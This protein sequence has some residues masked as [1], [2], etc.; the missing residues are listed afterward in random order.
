[1]THFPFAEFTGSPYELGHQHG[2]TFR[3]Q[4]RRQVAEMYDVAAQHELTRDAA[5]A[6]AGEQLPKIEALGPHWIDELRGLAQ[7]AGIKFEEAVSLQVRPGSGHMPDGCT[8]FGVSSDATA[9][10]HPL[11]GQNRDLGPVYQDRLTVSLLRPTEGPAVLMHSVPGELGG[12]GLNSY[13][14]SLFANSLWA[15]SGRTWMAPP[16]LRRAAL[17]C[18][19]ADA[20]VER[21][22]SMD[23]PA[24]GNFLLIDAAGRMR[25]LEILPE[26]VAVIASDS[27]AYA[28][29]NNC[30]AEELLPHEL[31]RLPLPGSEG[32]RNHLQ[33]AFDRE[34]GHISVEVCKR[35]LSDETGTPEPVCHRPHQGDP[36]ATVA[37]MIAEP[38]VGAL[39]ISF[40]PPSDGRFATHRVEPDAKD[41]STSLTGASN[42]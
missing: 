40:G 5:L 17:E 7:G 34:S 16:L 37:G 27:G 11:G 32:R 18:A 14:L 20:A 23:G 26:G 41:V 35:L 3:V 1:M 15:T 29:A 22:Q 31:P 42:R 36:Y 24:V 10:G 39:H 19:D 33:Q 25:N 9:D 30:T 21:I 6:W 8:S 2:E 12:T 28:H 4:I 38:A 13:G